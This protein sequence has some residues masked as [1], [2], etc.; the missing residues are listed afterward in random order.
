[1]PTTRFNDGKVD[2][3]GRFLAGTMDMSEEGPIGSL[4]RLDPDFKVTKLDSGII[5]SNGPCWSPDDKTFYFQDTWAG[6]IWA[7]DYDIAT[8]TPSNRRVFA[9]LDTKTGAADGSTVDAEGCLWNAQVFDGKLVRYRA[10]RHGRP[11]HRHAGQEGIERHVRRREPRHPLRHLDGEAPAAA[12]S[13]RWRAARQPVRDP[14]A[15]RAR[16]AGAEVWGLGGALWNGLPAP[17]GPYMSDLYVQLA[18]L[19]IEPA[20]LEA[21]MMA[22]EQQIEIAVGTEPVSLLLT[23][24]KTGPIQRA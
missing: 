4:Y 7:Y 24:F 12:S 15:R 8:G 10:G 2:R 20:Q 9:K 14:W 6:E 19:E 5:V 22:I 13:R 21:Y 11:R 18:V 23:R 16:H 3:R 17:N 1:M